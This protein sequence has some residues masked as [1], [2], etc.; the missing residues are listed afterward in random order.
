MMIQEEPPCLLRTP[1]MFPWMNPICPDT[2]PTP[3]GHWSWRS[4]PPGDCGL[5]DAARAGRGGARPAGAGPLGR[6][7]RAHAGSGG[8]AAGQRLSGG[9]GGADGGGRPSRRAGPCGAAGTASL[10]SSVPPGRRFGGPRPGPPPPDG[11]SPR[12]SPYCPSPNGSCPLLVP[13]LTWALLCQL[14]GLCGDLAALQEEQT[15][16]APLSLSLPGCGPCPMGT[17]GRCWSR[18]AGWRLS[19]ARTRRDVMA[20][21]R[22]PHAGDTGDRCAVWRERAAWGRRRRPGGSWS[23][24]GRGRGGAPRGLVPLPPPAGGRRK[25]TVRGVLRPAGP[26]L[27]RP[28]LRRSGSAAGQLGGGLLLFFPCPIW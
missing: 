25:D 15:G 5:G 18:R 14:R 3:P 21:W 9:A 17:G 6:G 7:E 22:T 1:P 24:P 13:A 27:C 28:A 10:F 23:C 26:A 12:S 16:P 2:G 8:V 11:L 19:C 4:G 20:P